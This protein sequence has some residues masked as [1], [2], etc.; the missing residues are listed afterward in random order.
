MHRIAGNLPY[1]ISTQIILKMIKYNKRIKDMHFLVQKEVAEKIAGA[2]GTKD[3]GKMGIKL[4]AFFTTEIL[5]DV[6]PEAFDIKPKVN[7]SF[8]R[9]TPLKDKLL[10]DEKIKDFFEIIDLS[11]TSRRKNI[12]N[13]LKNKNIEWSKIGINEKSRP[14]ELNLE[15]FLKIVKEVNKS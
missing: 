7:S 13:N 12:K 3:W 4:A 14:E 2:P 10:E 6:P 9:M 11:F 5:F 8:I 1:N 15:S